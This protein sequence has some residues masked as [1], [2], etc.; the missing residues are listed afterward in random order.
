MTEATRPVL[1]WHGGKWKLAPWIIENLPPHRVYVEPFGGAASVLIR[2]PRSYAEVYNDLDDDV[3]NLFRILRD[4]VAAELLRQ[5]LILTPFARLEHVEAYDRSED[6]IE[7]AR[8]LVV[9]SF[10]GFGSNGHNRKRRTGFRSNS[11]RSGTT[12]AQDWANYP[13]MLRAFT[14]RLRG[15]VV[16]SRPAIEVMAQHDGRETLHYVDPPYLPETRS[17]AM[18]M[19]MPQCYAHEMTAQQHG[20]LLTALYALK[21]MVV[22]SGYPSQTYDDALPGWRKV[23]LAAHAD[24]AAD[25]TEVLWLNPAAVAASDGRQISLFEAA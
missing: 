12:P 2:K 8:Q 23:E 4:P 25:R 17:A 6:A 15:V 22:L 1:R 14:E 13:E 10:M 20:E 5:A 3:V 18:A 7:A 21:G 11:N 24:G 19:P 16:E 9:L